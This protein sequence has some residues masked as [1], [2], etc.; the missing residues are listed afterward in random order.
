MNELGR[1]CCAS[2]SPADGS[3]SGTACPVRSDSFSCSNA[4]AHETGIC[5]NNTRQTWIWAERS[6]KS[7]FI[8]S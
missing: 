8:R 3:S 4:Y 6:S 7:R 5:R 1:A 2:M